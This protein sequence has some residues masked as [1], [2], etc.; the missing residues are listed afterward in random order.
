MKKFMVFV[1][2]DELNEILNYI[3][4]LEE[5]L[6]DRKDDIRLAYNEIKLLEA[7]KADLREEQQKKKLQISAYEEYLAKTN[8]L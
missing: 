5:E 7:E 8:Q 3:K 6:Q 4:L 2:C 1:D